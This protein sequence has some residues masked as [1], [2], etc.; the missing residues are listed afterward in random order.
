L[1]GKRESSQLHFNCWATHTHTR[2][3]I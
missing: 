2:R 1:T 3:C